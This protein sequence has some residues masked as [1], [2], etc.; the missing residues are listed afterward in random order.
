MIRILISVLLM[1]ISAGPATAQLDALLGGDDKMPIQ[2]CMNL[3]GALESPRREG[4]WG[5]TVRRED[6]Q[7]LKDAGFD[8]VRLPIKWSARMGMKAPYA[9]DKAFLARVDEIVQWAGQ[10]GLNIIIN[11]HHYDLLNERPNIHEKRLVALWDQLAYHYATAPEFV[12]FE[13]LNEPHGE[14]TVRRTDQLNRRLLKRIRVDNPDRWVILATAEWGGLDGLKKSRPAYDNRAILTY[15]D[16]SPFDF[17]HQGAPW[18]EPQR[19]MG[20]DWGSAEDLADVT[21][22][23]ASAK[24]IS[25]RYRMPLFV[26][27]FGV[28]EKVPLAQRAAWVKAK[29]ESFEAHGLAWC[30]WDF[31]TT[32]KSYD[33]EDEAW[34]PEMKAA[35]LGPTS[36]A[37]PVTP[38]E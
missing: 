12:I 4:E 33:V 6:M 27:E 20:V 35:L 1:V 25:E 32:L 17:T 21:A 14:M 31:A 16:Y 24:A 36:M 9:I 7:R 38:V 22:E 29:R 19:P 30:H 26:G 18:T 23:T 15:H 3:G 28:Y 2:R 13:T 34:I 8:T 5:Y 37:G 10:I 11:V